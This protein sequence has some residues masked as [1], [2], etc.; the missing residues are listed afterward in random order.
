M[1]AK[2]VKTPNFPQSNGELGAFCI[3]WAILIYSQTF[4]P[5]FPKRVVEMAAPMAE[6]KIMQFLFCEQRF[7]FQKAYVEDR[8]IFLEA[9]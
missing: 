5:V 7:S 2:T 8:M 6:K 4:L 9:M 1:V 3:S